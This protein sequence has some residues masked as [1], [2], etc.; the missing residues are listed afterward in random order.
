M[1]AR[2]SHTIIAAKSRHESPDFY[3]QILE[4]ERRT[5]LEALRQPPTGR[6][7]LLQFAEPPIDCPPQRYAFFMREV[8]ST[9]R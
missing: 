7:V 4:A 6:R 3:R 2:F 1:T 5:C 8:T 9:E